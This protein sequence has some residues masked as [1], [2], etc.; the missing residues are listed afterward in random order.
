MK[1]PIQILYFQQ[2]FPIPGFVNASK[3]QHT[4]VLSVTQ[5]DTTQ[6]GRQEGRQGS[7]VNTGVLR[8]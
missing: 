2:Q 6:D 7:H 3:V 8:I 4:A 5:C 1:G